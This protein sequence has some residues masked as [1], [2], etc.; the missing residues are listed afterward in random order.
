[1]N[2]SQVESIHDKINATTT[3]RKLQR[4]NKSAYNKVKAPTGKSSD[5]KKLKIPKQSESFND[6][7]NTPTTK[8]KLPKQNESF[9]PTTKG[10]LQ[11]RVKAG[12]TKKTVQ[13][14]KESFKNKV[15]ASTIK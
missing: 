4:Q 5:W 2:L 1:M 12:M 14:Q 13:K 11:N 15:K 10:K 3:K 9:N 6:K 8:R 7:I